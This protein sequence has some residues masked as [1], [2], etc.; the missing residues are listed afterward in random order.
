MV[1][2]KNKNNIRSMERRLLLLYI[3]GSVNMRRWTFLVLTDVLK[4][5]QYLASKICL[6][7][8][9]LS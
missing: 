1:I 3:A 9:T 2:N 7:P 5:Y 4:L 6:C 8:R